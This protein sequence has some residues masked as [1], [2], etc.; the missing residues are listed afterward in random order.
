MRVFYRSG[1]HHTP[2][3]QLHEWPQYRLFRQYLTQTARAAAHTLPGSQDMKAAYR[4]FKKQNPCPV[5]ATQPYTFTGWKHETVPPVTATVPPLTLP[6][7]P[8]EAKPTQTTVI[9]RGARWRIPKHHMTAQDLPKV[10][11]DS[12]RMPSTCWACDPN[13]P[14]TPWPVLNLIARQPTHPTAHLPPQAYAW[15]APWFHR[16]DVNSTVAWNP[17][18]KP[19][20]RFTTTPTGPR[21]DPARMAIRYSMYEPGRTDKH[22]HPY[23]PLH[24]SCHT[25]EHRT[26]TLTCRDLSPDTAYILHYIY[27]YLTQG[28]PEQG[29]IAMSPHAK[30]IISKGIRVYATPI[31]QSTTPVAH[32]TTGLAIYAY[33]RMNPCRLPQPSPADLLFFTD[34]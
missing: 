28:Q 4:D 34:A 13:A 16:T 21:P 3:L 30:S 32:L 26:Q 20:W 5:P 9:H 33:L 24:N 7:A 12:Q 1:A 22:K 14:T 6:L 25:A 23:Y 29:L 31:L 15:V 2:L 11:H 18:H 27:S 19:K 8:N 17:D 10:P